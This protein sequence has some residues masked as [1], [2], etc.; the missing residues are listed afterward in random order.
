MTRMAR[1]YSLSSPIFLTQTVSR[2]VSL[3]KREGG[4]L[5]LKHEVVDAELH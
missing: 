3:F 4:I 5:K 2:I 1:L